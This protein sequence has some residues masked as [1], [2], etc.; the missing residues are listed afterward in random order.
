MV[1]PPARDPLLSPSAPAGRR[2]PSRTKRLIELWNDVL[3]AEGL[4]ATSSFA[5][6]RNPAKLASARDPV[7][8]DK[9][10][11]SWQKI[12]KKRK[13]SFGLGRFREGF[14]EFLPNLE[15]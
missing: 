7:C 12:Q 14:A 9:S 6:S 3:R 8:D 5:E 15:L 2:F 11:F 1:K 10:D 13:P 4:W